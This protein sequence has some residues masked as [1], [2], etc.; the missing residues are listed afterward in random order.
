MNQLRNSQ[1]LEIKECVNL[2]SHI[3]DFV[4]FNLLF[5]NN[6]SD[7][8]IIIRKDPIK[9]TLEESVSGTTPVVYSE[10]FAKF[11]NDFKDR[12]ILKENY[13]ENFNSVTQKIE[14]FKELQLLGRPGPTGPVGCRGPRGE[15]GLNGEKGEQGEQGIQGTKGERGLKGERGPIGEIG[16]RG[17]SG[18]RGETGEKGPQ[19]EKGPRGDPFTYDDFTKDQL[20]ALK[21]PKGEIGNVG[22]KG[23]SFKFKDFSKQQL[24][25]LKGEKGDRGPKGD[26]GY[27]GEKGEKGENGE[28]GPKGHK[29]EK[30]EDG[31]RGPPGEVDHN[32]VAELAIEMDCLK[33]SVKD[34]V[35]TTCI[36]ISNDIETKLESR[37]YKEK[38]A[39][40]LSDMVYSKIKDK[41][42]RDIISKG[43][44]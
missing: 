40:E 33:K 28:R 6:Q 37:E 21:G 20:V 1:S 8:G 26:K 34:F 16:P 5:D 15:I 4:R 14:E 32:V 27:K 24:E 39:N 35:T 43:S 19:G 25:M 10:A 13:E 9:M 36:K 23:D 30:G 42:L 3:S 22:P 31:E 2:K 11:Y 7:S 38:L 17:P 18:E 29:G 41:L 12:F 44:H